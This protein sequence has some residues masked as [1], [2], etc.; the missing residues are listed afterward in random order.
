MQPGERQ[1]LKTAKQHNSD[2]G[3]YHFDPDLNLARIVHPSKS[4]T[5][6]LEALFKACG[7]KV[8]TVKAH[9]PKISTRPYKRLKR[10]K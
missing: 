9:K 6:I 2:V 7:W 8:I 5:D 3:E 4:A 1:G 10:K